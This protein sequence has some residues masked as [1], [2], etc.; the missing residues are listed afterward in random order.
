MTA[1]S[2]TITLSSALN[3]YWRKIQ[4]K[5]AL[6]FAAGKRPERQL[7]NQFPTFD[8]PMSMYEVTRPLDLQERGGIA[9]IPEGGYMASPSNVNAIEATMTCVQFNGRISISD[10]AKYADRGMGNQL[11]VQLKNQA[12]Q[13][14][15]AMTEHFADYLHG[16]ATALLAVTDSTISGTTGNVLTLKSG[17]GN[18]LITNGRY[19]ASLFKVGERIVLTTASDVLINGV[20]SFALITAVSKSAG[21]IT[22]TMDGS[23]SYSTAGTRIY[24]ANNLEGATVAGG[25]DQ[26][27]GLPGFQDIFES[28][29]LHGVSGATYANWNASYS[30]TVA[31]RFTFT[32]LQRGKDETLNTGGTVADVLMISQGVKRD[33]VAQERA[34][35]RYEDSMNMN[36]DGDVEAKGIRQFSTKGVPP[37][38]ARLFPK[39]AIEKWEI[40]PTEENMAWG[41]LMPFQDQSGRTGRI[42]WY[43]SVVVNNRAALAYW[44]SQTEA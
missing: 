1:Q 21:T 18:A 24:K 19:I 36:F 35:L 32:K 39:S 38:Y 17:Y 42:D 9:S 41:D 12:T 4:G 28:T 14:V 26:G 40:L 8:A 2:N 25:S 27:K 44:S 7:Y 33:M 11:A 43:G 29:T 30:D 20:S 10:I 13:K 15:Q 5:I 34:G 22:V 6:G 16:S 3:K 37:G 31:G 23:T